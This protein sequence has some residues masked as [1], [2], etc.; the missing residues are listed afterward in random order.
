[1]GLVSEMA[2]T[3]PQAA[4]S[5]SD[6]NYNVSSRL[7]EH[8]PQT[9]QRAELT[10]CLAALEKIEE[11]DL[12]RNYNRQ[13]TPTAWVIVT[14]SAYL[15]DSMTQYIYRWKLNGYIAANGRGVVNAD[16]F[17]RID[18]RLQDIAA[19][20]GFDILFWKEPRSE[21]TKADSLAKE[22]ARGEDYL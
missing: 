20:G 13:Q 7:D 22:G 14:D 3:A 2:K 9:S 6:S 5:G 21:N 8:Q 16:L 1:M 11:A 10:A 15:V 18:Q 12:D 4:T 17:R 19:E